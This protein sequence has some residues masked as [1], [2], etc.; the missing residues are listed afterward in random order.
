M[1]GFQL[2]EWDDVADLVER[3]LDAPVAARDP[4]L[5]AACDTDAER[6][7]RARRVLAAAERASSFLDR[8][9]AEVAP[10]LVAT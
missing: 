1:P 9:V 2:S 4:I 8:P 10:D 5:R 6:L 3:A 7:A